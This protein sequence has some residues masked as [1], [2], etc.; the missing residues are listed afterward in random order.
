VRQPLPIDDTLPELREALRAHGAVVLEAPPG[1]GKT[2]RVPLMVAELVAGAVWV[3]EPR[4]VA[5]RA[6][7]HRVAAELGEPV[8][9]TVGYAMRLDRRHGADTRVLYVTE[10]L[11][12]RRLDDFAE[13]GAVVLDEFHERSIHTDVALAWV[14]ALRRSR[15]ELVLVVM[16]ATLDAAAVAQYLG[17]PRVRA[18]GRRFPVHIRHLDRK[19]DRP[20]EVR[21]SAAIRAVDGNVLAFLPGVGE[22]ER[23][24]ALLADFDLAPLHGE[25]DG[26]AQ[27]R[28]LRAP[29]PG[30]GRRRVVLA[31]N[32]AETSVTVE[33]VDTVVDCGLVRQAAWDPWSGL[34]T[35]D[36]V[37]IAQDAAA[38]RAGR[39]GRTGPGACLRLYSQGDHDS[40]SPQTAPEVRR[41]DLA[42]TALALGGRELEW[43]EAPPP[44][45]WRASVALLG[46]LGAL[47]DGKR[48]A[49]GEEMVR[50]PLPPRLA[51]VLIEG[52]ARGVAPEAARLV[53]LFGRR[54]GGDLVE[55]ALDGEG[56]PA[57]A[58]RLLA[59]VGGGRRAPA[60]PA[61]ALGQALLAGFSDRIARREGG[62]VR[63]ADGGAA[64][65]EALRDGFVVVTEV[66]R[67]GTRTR[68]RSMSPVEEDWL[69]ERAEMRSTMT[70]TGERVDVK[71]VLQFGDLVLDAA[72]GQGDPE[73][74]ARLLFEHAR[75]VMHR[76]VPDWDRGLGLLDRL[77]F[78]RSRGHAL[79]TLELDEL[80][81]ALCGGCRSLGDLGATS[82]V[83]AIRVRLPDDLPLDRLAPETVRLPGRLRAPVGYD[84]DE[85]WVESRIQDFFGLPDGPRIAGDTPL[86]LRLLAPNQRPVQVTRD[87]AGF[88]DRHYPALRKELMRRY[89][90]HAWPENPRTA[91][92]EPRPARDR[93]RR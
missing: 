6:A 23:T 25:L 30:S 46:R 32:V 86:V 77:R 75:A 42:A 40:R 22:I 66:E 21:M 63:L 19:D 87:L 57:E 7:A 4:R 27:D 82:L 60:D 52:A 84:G 45:A 67:I 14:R 83:E 85:P 12:T 78:L 38:Q 79:E 2:T 70:W 88:W 8:G 68:A 92:A 72:P 43:F 28:A 13:L 58:R 1:S 37:P 51:R 62:R 56:D 9:A 33:G 29:A 16:S 20:I 11:L 18:E 44:A 69:L 59:M 90:R 5:A 73:A 34:P 31:T 74:V 48:S 65:C 53:T 50:L 15:P 35:L 26:A 89:P 39:A 24:A 80:A 81:A 71:D 91:V 49:I 10:A 41:I 93:E 3:L 76:H 55:R 61:A 17:C 54:L 64:E 47:E 36:L